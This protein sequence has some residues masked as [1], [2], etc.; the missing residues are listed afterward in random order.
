MGR[1]V[2]SDKPRAKKESKILPETPYHNRRWRLNHFKIR[3]AIIDLLAADK[4]HDMPTLDAIAKAAGIGVKRLT[5]HLKEIT[6]EDQV[7]AVRAWT[8]RVNAALALKAASGNP[9]AI[10]LYHQIIE[11]WTE[12]QRHEIEGDLRV[13]I[14]IEE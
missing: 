13:V 6:P 8:P 7:G 4:S 14:D 10:K 9:L 11:G 1:T 3:K 5:E 12:K 2:I